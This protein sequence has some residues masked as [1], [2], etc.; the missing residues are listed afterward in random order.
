MHNE[1]SDTFCL[2][3]VHKSYLKAAWEST[4]FL[5]KAYFKFQFGCDIM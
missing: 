1:K 4:A 5:T 3:I 2:F